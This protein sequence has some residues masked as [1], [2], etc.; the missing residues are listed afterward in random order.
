MPTISRFQGIIIYMYYNDAHR[1][2]HF[3]VRYGEER[4]LVSVEHPRIMAGRLSRVQERRVL[5][6]AEKRHDELLAI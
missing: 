5:E 3:H 2:A 1:I 4:A 6:W